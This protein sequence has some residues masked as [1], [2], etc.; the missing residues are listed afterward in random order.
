MPLILDFA[1]WPT[2]LERLKRAVAGEEVPEDAA[3]QDQRILEIDRQARCRKAR[4]ARARVR[5]AV[6]AMWDEGDQ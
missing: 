1:K 5:A 4:E 2:D 6:Q 3:V